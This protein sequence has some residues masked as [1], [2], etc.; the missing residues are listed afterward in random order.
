MGCKNSTV[1]CALVGL[2][3]GVLVQNSYLVVGLLIFGDEAADVVH[4]IAALRV[5]EGVVRV[6]DVDVDEV[7]EKEAEEG[8]T[9]QLGVHVRVADLALVVVGV[10]HEVGEALELGEVAAVHV[11]GP[12]L[13]QAVDGLG[14]QGHH[15]GHE[16]VEGVELV[17]ALGHLDEVGDH[18]A[19]PVD[20]LAV[21]D[22]LLRPEGGLIEAA[23]ELHDVGRLIHLLARHPLAADQLVRL[24]LLE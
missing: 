12:G 17:E 15:D 16:R 10:E 11:L 9:G 7:G 22:L 6:G 13:A 14:A 2:V 5:V 8:D 20:P 21:E 19:A 1:D 24:D 23:C 18:L 4:L 3:F